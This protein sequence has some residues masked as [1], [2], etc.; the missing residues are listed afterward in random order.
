L[1]NLLKTFSAGEFDDQSSFSQEVNCGGTYG[2][3]AVPTMRSALEGFCTDHHALHLSATF[4]ALNV[5]EGS[6]A[7]AH[8]GSPCKCIARDKHRP[9]F[10]ELFVG[11][12]II[13]SSASKP[14]TVELDPWG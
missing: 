13:S 2:L 9:S 6:W 14:E 10:V 4:Y 7:Q 3:C 1:S 11:T 8:N 12:N 5:C